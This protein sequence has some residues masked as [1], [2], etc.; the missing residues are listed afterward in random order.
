MKFFFDTE[1]IESG[2]G[3]AIWPL[4]VGIACEGGG[5]F[6][7]E[8]WQ[9][10]SI[11]ALANAFV[12]RNV[13]PRLASGC[14]DLTSEYRTALSLAMDIE[15]WVTE[16]CAGEGESPEFWAYYADYDW[17]VLCQLFGRMVDLPPRWPKL[18]M[19]VRQYAAHHGLHDSLPEQHGGAHHALADARHAMVM[20]DFVL[21]R[22]GVEA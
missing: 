21:A 18:C 7:G 17:V 1:F 3:S 10:P 8:V 13:L 12:R 20:H 4:S 5:E 9:P 22:A 14:G 6:Y 15:A 19:D 11:H 2:Y 16:I